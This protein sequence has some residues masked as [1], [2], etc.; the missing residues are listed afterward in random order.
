[1]KT[2]PPSSQPFRSKTLAILLTFLFFIGVFGGAAGID[3]NFS[4]TKAI[5]FPSS[6]LSIFISIFI[7]F[8]L[9][10]SNEGVNLNPNISKISNC[11]LIFVGFF[12]LS[13]LF[14]LLFTTTIPAVI[15]S[16]FGSP[17]TAEDTVTKIEK[18]SGKGCT[19]C[20]KNL[21]LENHKKTLGF[22]P[23]DTELQY[24]KVG[25]KIIVIGYQSKL[26]IRIN[27]FLEAPKTD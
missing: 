18:C 16:F 27:S 21:W 15:T 10:K 14:S 26:G 8:A 7:L 1:M 22:C 12:I 6:I 19:F 5:D 23:S 4:P 13:F 11:I 17:Y 3:I 2:T 25:D 9:I 24:L 20:S